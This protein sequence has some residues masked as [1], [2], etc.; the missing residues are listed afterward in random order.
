MLCLHRPE[1]VCWRALYDEQR[2]TCPA[3]SYSLGV[4][5]GSSV[6]M[7]V[8]ETAWGCSHPLCL[9]WPA[10]GRHGRSGTL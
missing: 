1:A 6:R 4:M 5:L 3:L 2:V 8:M 7:V 9:L 10:S